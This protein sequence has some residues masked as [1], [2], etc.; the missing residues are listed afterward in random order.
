MIYAA[1]RQAGKFGKPPEIGTFGLSLYSGTAPSV[2][3][4]LSARV[5]SRGYQMDPNG[6]FDQTNRFIQSLLFQL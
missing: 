1:D 3:D 2:F 4:S 5:K 6:D